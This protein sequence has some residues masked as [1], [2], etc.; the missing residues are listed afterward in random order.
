MPPAGQAELRAGCRALSPG[1]KGIEGWTAGG[2]GGLG[3]LRGRV[4]AG[5]FPA[6]TAVDGP[7]RAATLQGPF[8]QRGW[9]G[10]QGAGGMQHTCMQRTE[11][12]P[13]R[14]RVVD[15]EQVW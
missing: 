2:M 14:T 13:A 5:G 4:H 3:A 8:L 1:L 10:Q 6:G 11:P 15:W 7:G 9:R 12:P